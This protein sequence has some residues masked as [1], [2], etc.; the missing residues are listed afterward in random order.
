METDENEILAK[1]LDLII[2]RGGTWLH[3]EKRANRFALFNKLKRRYSH[4]IIK[5]HIKYR[6]IKD[7][8]YLS[9]L[10]VTEK[11]IF[12]PEERTCSQC[13]NKF[14]RN[15]VFK[16][17][18][19]LEDF[20]DMNQGSYDDSLCEICLEKIRNDMEIKEWNKT[21]DNYRTENSQWSRLH[22]CDY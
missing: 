13:E 16:V 7:I 15:D 3:M 9:H 17:D 21:A 22:S 4:N 12:N 14:L 8:N 6:Q 11:G 20:F 10:R 2:E 18:R 1:K 5:A 19:H